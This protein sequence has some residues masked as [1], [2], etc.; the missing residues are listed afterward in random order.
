MAAYPLSD[1]LGRRSA[2]ASHDP[3]ITLVPLSP[4]RCRDPNAIHQCM[5]KLVP[6]FCASGWITVRTFY[7]RIR[8]DVMTNLIM[9]RSA[10]IFNQLEFKH[11]QFLQASTC[12]K[13]KVYCLL[14]IS[15]CY[16]V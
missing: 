9:P 2:S 10:E 8:G 11:S 15:H 16:T 12:K 7:G 6:T 14:Y 1:L 3:H 13:A 5:L 4:L